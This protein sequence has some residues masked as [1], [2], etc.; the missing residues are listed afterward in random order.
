MTKETYSKMTGW[1]RNNAKLAKFIHILNK[2]ITIGIFLVYPIFLCYLLIEGNKRLIEAVMVP[3][4]SFL[5]VSF[6]RKLINRKRPYE[7]FNIPPVIA[8]DTSGQSFPSRHVFSAFIISM[9]V[10]IICPYRIIGIVML[11]LSALL[12]IIRI[13]SGVHYIS[14]VLAGAVIAIL[15]G[16]IFY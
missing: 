9:T 16:I 11:I 4:V 10:L 6:F 3:A 1:L 13:I 14:D 12:G 5:L 7:K 15:V 2:G 8:K